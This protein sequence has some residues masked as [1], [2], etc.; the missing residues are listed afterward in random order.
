MTNQIFALT[1]ALLMAGNPVWSQDMPDIDEIVQVDLI[2]GW[3][4][5]S[6][7]YMAALRVTLAPGWKT[8]W[9][10]GGETGIPPRFDWS[11]SENL[12]AV[13]YHWPRPDILKVD[14]VKIIGYKNELILPIE[15]TP[16]EAGATVNISATAELGICKDICIPVNTTLTASLGTTPGNDDFLIELALADGAVTGSEIG[17]A[18]PAC[19]LS[20]VEDGFQINAEF[21]LPATAAP[22]DFV[23][24]ESPDPNVWVAP[25][26]QRLEGN[27][28]YAETLL[29][30][31]GDD[32]FDVNTRDLRVT[33]ISH[34]QAIDIQGC[35]LR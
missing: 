32:S 21:N 10:V 34:N 12:N 8:Y 18:N 35:D 20:P 6:G 4:M 22:T 15:F 19:T 24:F 26:T 7:A 5:E 16:T 13:K 30:S 33:L 25:A 2:P 3:Q 14:D 27:M 29:L 1:T 11:G 28:L 31:Y 9:R 23:V 17:Y